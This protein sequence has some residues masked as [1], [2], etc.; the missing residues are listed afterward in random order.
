MDKTWALG[1]GGRNVVNIIPGQSSL[2][3]SLTHRVPNLNLTIACEAFTHSGWAQQKLFAI[4][5]R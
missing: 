1:A 2:Q 3:W 5:V 4:L